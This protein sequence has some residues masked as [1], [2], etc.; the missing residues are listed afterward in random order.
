LTG[1]IEETGQW[2]KLLISTGSSV[3]RF[4]NRFYEKGREEELVYLF[5]CIEEPG[6]TAGHEAVKEVP[7]K[8]RQSSQ[9]GRHDH[10]FVETTM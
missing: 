7:S 3:A 5:E 8:G 10:R 4:L 9:A 6:M 1:W 2:V